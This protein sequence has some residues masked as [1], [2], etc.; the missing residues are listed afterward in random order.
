[1]GD[2]TYVT[3]SV[4]SAHKEQVTALS[5]DTYNSDWEQPTKHYFVFG[6]VNYGELDFLDKL[7]DAGIAYD[8]E[9]E[10]GSEYGSG[11]EH[12]RFTAE[13]EIVLKEIYDSEI[14]PNLTQLI[15]LID[16]PEALRNFI[17]HH[18]EQ[19]TTLPWDNQEEYGKLYRTKQLIAA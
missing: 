14:N 12:C 3:L 6:E 10:A 13:G 9:W 8:S 15:S 5:E 4:L 19:I 7:Q 16:Q 11:G 1:M 2:R 18:K 17:L